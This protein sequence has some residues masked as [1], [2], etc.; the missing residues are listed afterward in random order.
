MNKR[1]LAALLVTVI[2]LPAFADF[3][4]LAKAIESQQGVRKVWIPFL[5][6][7]RAAVWTVRPKGVRDFQ[8]ATF[9]LD[10]DIDP[11]RMQ[12]IVTA[13]MERGFAPIV[14]VRSKRSGEWNFIYA[15]PRQDGKFVEL[16]I[17]SHENSEAVLVR[18]EVDAETLARQLGEP[19]TA[20]RMA[21]R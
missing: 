15:R 8:L 2:A 3:H 18:V 12:K 16:M 17:V 1:I 10:K 5:G 11:A 20:S 21:S 4:S 9:E 19:R 6:L 13:H 14:Q 7:A